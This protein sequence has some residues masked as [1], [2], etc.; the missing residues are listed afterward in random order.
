MA[1][2]KAWKGIWTFPLFVV[3]LVALLITVPYF[4]LFAL[5][6]IFYLIVANMWWKL[7]VLHFTHFYTLP[8]ILK[9]PLLMP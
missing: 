5:I 7:S 1:S 8:M 6:P 2:N 4:Q 3:M 9:S